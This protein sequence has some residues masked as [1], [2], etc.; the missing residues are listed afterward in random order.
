MVSCFLSSV[1]LHCSCH[2]TLLGSSWHLL[3]SCKMSALFSCSSVTFKVS[4][5]YPGWMQNDMKHHSYYADCRR[6]WEFFMI[7]PYSC[8]STLFIPVCLASQPGLV[9]LQVDQM[10]GNCPT[11]FYLGSW[12]I[13]MSDH[14]GWIE[15]SFITSLSAS[16]SPSDARRFN[17]F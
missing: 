6:M 5:N 16:Q 7:G 9:F 12:N 15:S 17:H 3:T 2:C 8:H 13:K 11:Y 10:A 14:A 4:L 1:V